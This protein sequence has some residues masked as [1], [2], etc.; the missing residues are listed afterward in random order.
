[1]TVPHVASGRD[2]VAFEAHYARVDGPNFDLISQGLPKADVVLSQSE[3]SMLTQTSAAAT[4][5]SPR[6]SRARPESGSAEDNVVQ[7]PEEI[8]GLSHR[9]LSPDIAARAYLICS[10]LVVGVLRDNV[11]EC[12]RLAG[13]SS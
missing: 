9:S 10:T 8:R 5:R 2:P 12:I 13:E 7:R 6:L 3:G 1:M 4:L 11:H